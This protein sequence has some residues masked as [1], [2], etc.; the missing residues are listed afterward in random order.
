MGGFRKNRWISKQMKDRCTDEE[1]D[2]WISERK[3]EWMNNRRVM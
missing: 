1:K 3:E 2:G